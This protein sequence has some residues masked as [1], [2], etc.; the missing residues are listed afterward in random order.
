M[1]EEGVMQRE[2]HVRRGEAIPF[3]D[4]NQILQPKEEFPMETSIPICLKYPCNWDCLQQ[5]LDLASFLMTDQIDNLSFAI[6]IQAHLPI[7][8]LEY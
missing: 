6:E 5:P 4:Q 2:P 7:S 8:L 3:A 1:C